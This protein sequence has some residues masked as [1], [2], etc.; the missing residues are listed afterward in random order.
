MTPAESSILTGFR[1]VINSAKIQASTATCAG[2]W[3]AAHYAAIDLPPTQRASL[4][5]AFLAAVTM[6]FRE[7]VNAWGTE[8]AAAATAAIPAP[9]P[10]PPSVQVNTG[11]SATNE[12]TAVAVPP[13]TAKPVTVAALSAAPAP[14]ATLHLTPLPKI[15]GK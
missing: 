13:A 4:W 14:Q 8:D 12:Q 7:C 10:A 3:V 2:M 6:L 9:P 1:R 11:A 5:I 15:P